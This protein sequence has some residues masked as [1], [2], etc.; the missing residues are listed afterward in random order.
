MA[1]RKKGYAPREIFLSRGLCHLKWGRASD[2]QA[3][4]S[5]STDS[6]SVLLIPAPSVPL[7]ARAALTAHWPE[8]LME[9]AGLGLFMV[10]ACVFGALYEFPGSPVRQALASGDLRRV[11]MGLTMGLTAIAIIYSPWG[12]QSGAHINPATTLT[13]FR[14]GKVQK[15]DAIFYAMAQFIGGVVG[16]AVAAFF[17]GH[18]LS[19]PS[20]NFVATKPGQRG[21][22]VAALAEVLMTFGLM[23]L[24]LKVTNSRLSRYTGLFVGVTVAAYIS[25][26]APLSGM[27]L[28]PAR[29]FASAF[30]ASDYQAIFI[31]FIA[32][33][34]G[35][36]AAAYVYAQHQQ[37]P[38]ACA[39]LH[40][41]NPQRCI[42][43]GANGG[44]AS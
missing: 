15:W 23:T 26:E 42:F 4:K 30:F 2:A 8:Y 25:L 44:F 21:A 14:L 12:K 9:A 43:C 24:V 28:N 36:L 13:F 20:V 39:K 5:M 27:S 7:T 38:V 3:N 18:Q 22:L 35:M 11:L 6:Q 1:D 16:V 32:P 37:R 17:V 40:H 31:Y 33:P 29:T 41:D 34:A 19:S 10:S